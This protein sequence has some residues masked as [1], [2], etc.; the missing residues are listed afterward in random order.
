MITNFVACSVIFI[1][2]VLYLSKSRLHIR[3]NFL[4]EFYIVRRFLR[5]LNR[6]TP[7]KL[8]I[9]EEMD[10]NEEE[11]EDQI[12]IFEY[13]RIRCKNLK[14]D[15]KLL[16]PEE[17]M[18]YQVITKRSGHRAVCDDENLWTWGGYCP[19][20][21]GSPMLQEVIFIFLLFLK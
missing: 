1:I 9:D 14:T 18:K 7:V 21:E 10:L 5:N 17:H 15:N 3:I 6:F 19:K 13:F 20:D 11:N 2:S 8:L 4:T 12:G 16:K